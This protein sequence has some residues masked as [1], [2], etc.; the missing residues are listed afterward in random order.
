[1]GIIAA[2]RH[3]AFGRR[4][5]FSELDGADAFRRR[6]P[7]QT[8]E[9]LY[10]D[11]AAM[12]EGAQDRLCGARPLLWERTSGSGAEPKCIPYPPAA[13]A[14]FQQAIHPWLHDLL[15]NYPGIAR[16]RAYFSISPA[17]WTVSATADGTPVGAD[18]DSLYI[19]E[20]LRPH[21]ARLLAVPPALGRLS[22]MEVWRYL[23][24]R[25]LVEAQ[26]LTL[27]SVWS[28]TFLTGLLESLPRYADSLIEDL[29]EGTV[30]PPANSERLPLC[31]FQPR[32]ER[33]STVREF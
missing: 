29:R 6:V 24:L 11:I 32:P 28:P 2:N 25:F 3:T 4:H 30:S 10:P 16:G 7:V 33:G 27:I 5:G 1:M 31:R 8:W 12:L 19:G 18:D 22:D 13:L 15:L 21:L 17:S 23:T 14:A 26:D 20:V 9:D